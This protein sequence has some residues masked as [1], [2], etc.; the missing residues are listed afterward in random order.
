MTC[1]YALESPNLRDEDVRSA[2]MAHLSILAAEF[3]E[4]IPYVGGLQ[5]GF[6]FRGRRIPFLNRQ[7]GIYR[8]AAQTGPAALS[9]QTSAKS[10][11]DDEIAEDGFIYAYRSGDINQSDNR[12]LRAAY[13][14]QVPIVYFIGTRPGWYKPVFPC[15]VRSDDPVTRPLL[16]LRGRSWD[17][18]TSRLP[19]HSKIPSSV[20]TPYD[21]HEFVFIK[22]VSEVEWF[23]PTAANARFAR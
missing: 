19:R 8:S 13:K 22:R 1:T 4:D 18:W 20:V 6:P 3:G 21:R 11:Y 23:L 5:R 14:L 16:S 15:Y 10:P 17:R 9:I 2:C 7:K 12:A